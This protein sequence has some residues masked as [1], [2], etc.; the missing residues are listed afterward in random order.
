MYKQT[1][2]PRQPSKYALAAGRTDQLT[3]LRILLLITVHITTLSK[4]T[5][6]TRHRGASLS[7]PAVYLQVQ[8]LYTI[9]SAL[10]PTLNC[11]L[12][13]FDT[14]IGTQW[15]NSTHGSAQGPHCRAATQGTGK[16][17]DSFLMK[18]LTS[19]NKSQN[20][21]D[22][23]ANDFRPRHPGYQT[24]IRAIRA[25]ELE[26]RSDSHESVHSRPISSGKRR[27]GPCN[28]RRIMIPRTRY[29]EYLPN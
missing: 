26:P 5:H 25:T 22:N 10:V 24:D 23:D 14:S 21:H 17:D 9:F 1:D 28:M 2:V 18:S 27:T 15:R 20:G 6:T 8:V 13:K 4:S 3:H 7:T 16:M 19:T 12:R 11:W 29:N